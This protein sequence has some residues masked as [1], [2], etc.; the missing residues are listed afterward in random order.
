VHADPLLQNNN[1]ILAEDFPVFRTLFES[2]GIGSCE[3]TRHIVFQSMMKHFEPVTLTGIE[4][5]PD[6]EFRSDTLKHIAQRYTFVSRTMVID[7]EYQA[8][9]YEVDLGDGVKLIIRYAEPMT[10][11][12]VKPTNKES[13]L[14]LVF[15]YRNYRNRAC[16]LKKVKTFL[17]YL[18]Q[19]PM[20]PTEKVFYRPHAIHEW[21]HF[22]TLD[23][24]DYP[25]VTTNK[26]KRCY[27]RFFR[28]KPMDVLDD[29]GE[30]YWEIPFFE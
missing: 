2:L 17:E 23:M 15:L 14:Y 18:K 27:E 22:R 26:L 19:M 16:P 8:Q 13:W 24:V 9:G 1:K 6:G 10:G 3:T 12:S 28:A 4:S 7:V 11:G 30:P 20:C 25:N 29:K 5:R 21:Q